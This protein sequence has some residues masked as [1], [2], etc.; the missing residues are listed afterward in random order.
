MD[1]TLSYTKGELDEVTTL[2][3]LSHKKRA[4]LGVIGMP[5][6]RQILGY[7]YDPK[8]L[9]GDAAHPG[10]YEVSPDLSMKEI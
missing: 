1:A 9:I 6:R 2:I 3:G 10:V 8:V 7:A 5:Y 4:R